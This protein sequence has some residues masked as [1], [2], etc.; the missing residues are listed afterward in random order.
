M[1]KEQLSED[2]K[3]HYDVGRIPRDLWFLL[4][5]IGM[6]NIDLANYCSIAPQR[7][8]M[9]A[10]GMKMTPKHAEAVADLVD[11]VADVLEEQMKQIKD[12]AIKEYFGA[13]LNLIEE[14]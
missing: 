3:K 2:I 14:E 9:Y 5:V 8:S 7:V 12:K 6:N 11:A 4:K 13:M 1:D 10:H